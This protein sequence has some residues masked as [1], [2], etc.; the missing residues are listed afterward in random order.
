[1]A[2]HQGTFA[3]VAGHFGFEPGHVWIRIRAFLDSYQG[4]PSGMP[5][6]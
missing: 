2:S 4:M 6:R 5:Q 3:L 1:M